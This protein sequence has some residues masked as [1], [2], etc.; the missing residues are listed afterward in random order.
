MQWPRSS[1]RVGESVAGDETEL[2]RHMQCLQN[3]AEGELWL[4]VQ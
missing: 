4:S 2:T 3:R 1:S